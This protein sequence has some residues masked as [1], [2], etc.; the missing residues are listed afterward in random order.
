V[1]EAVARLPDVYRE[2]IVLRFYNGRSCAEI[3]RDLNVPLGTVTKRLSRAYAL[4][5][6]HLGRK[7]PERE[8]EVSR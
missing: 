3:S 4:L 1:T 7:L 2:V 8:S 5:R 6:E